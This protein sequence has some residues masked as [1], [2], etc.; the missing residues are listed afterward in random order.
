MPAAAATRARVHAIDCQ[1]CSQVPAADGMQRLWV[2][3]APPLAAAP[4]HPPPVTKQ[5]FDAIVAER[6]PWA[7]P[8]AMHSPD[9]CSGP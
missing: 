2:E 3:L 6:S 9:C 7:H 1:K 4:S 8:W 5:I